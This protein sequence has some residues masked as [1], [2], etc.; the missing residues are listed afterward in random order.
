MVGAVTERGPQ[1]DPAVVRAPD[2]IEPIVG[3]RVW[4][5]A[6]VDGRLLLGSLCFAVLW[7]P[8]T[9]MVASCSHVVASAAGVGHRV[10]DPGCN[11]GIHAVSSSDRALP[12][13]SR[14]FRGGP[15]TVHRVI[16]PVALWGT[17]VE[18]TRGWRSSH[19]YPQALYVPAA[20]L[21]ARG[22][23]HGVWRP[24]CPVDRIAEGLAGYGVPVSI[25]D[26]GTAREL[27]PLLGEPDRVAAG[28]GLS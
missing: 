10:P 26:G 2:L 16:G 20:R 22:L 4:D 6:Y 21:S 19:A 8:E 12:Y 3:W 24:R 14:L 18:G 7:Q 27:A 25:V 17:A 5:V 1:I 13:L 15:R 28:L 9:A 23:F 11:C